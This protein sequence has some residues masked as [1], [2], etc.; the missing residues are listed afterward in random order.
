MARKQTKTTPKLTRGKAAASPGKI[1]KPAGSRSSSGRAVSRVS[2]KR[3]TDPKP[4]SSPLKGLKFSLPWKRKPASRKTGPARST[5][6]IGTGLSLDRKLD[7]IG[8]GLAL[9]GLLTL[10]ALLSPNHGSVTGGWVNAIGK[11][12]GWGMYLFPLSAMMIGL[13]LVLR[14]FERVPQLSVERLLGLV[15]IYTNL[16]ADLHFINLPGSP[17][18]VYNLA[19]QGEG[20]GYLGGFLFELLPRKPGSRRRS[21]RSSSL[22][23]NRPWTKPGRIRGRAVPLDAAVIPALA[24]LDR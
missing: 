18:A 16:L 12:F 7:I 21:R 9:L 19:A 6:P 8:V 22:A 24:G 20:G 5:R 1:K 14:N 15:L 23:S 11:A 4:R 17:Q 3:E 2:V 13:W 10:L